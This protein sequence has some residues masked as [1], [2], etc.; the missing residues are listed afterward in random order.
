MAEK[1]LKIKNLVAKSS[2][3]KLADNLIS[4]TTKLLHRTKT[5]EDLRIGFEKLLEPI[6]KELGINPNPRYEKSIYNAGRSDALHGQ[7]VIEYEA[8]ISFK[9]SRAI[10]HA[11]DQLV[12]YIQ[13]LSKAEKETLFLLESKFVGVGFDGGQ[14]KGLFR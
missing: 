13:G 4:G 2:I 14:V 10:T 1:E 9:S 11:Y 5:E 3:H 7:V 12:S 8:P 6:L